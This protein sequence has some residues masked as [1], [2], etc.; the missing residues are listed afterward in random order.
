MV[1]VCI[2]DAVATTFSTIIGTLSRPFSFKSAIRIECLFEM[3]KKAPLSSEMI[4]RPI[5]HNSPER[6]MMSHSTDPTQK[7]GFKAMEC[8]CLHKY[9]V[10]IVQY[11]N[12]FIHVLHCT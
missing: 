7:T 3:I 12:N 1:P 8:M 4:K 11:V 2:L 9:L 6:I 5:Q 10:I